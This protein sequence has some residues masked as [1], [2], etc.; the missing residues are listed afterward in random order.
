MAWNTATASNY[1]DVLTKLV[2]AATSKYISA[3]AINS[4]GSSYT[5]GDILTI[6]H[7]GATIDAKIEVL[8]VSSGVITSAVIRSAGAFSNRVATV[9]VNAG[10]TGYAAGDIV[11]L[12][13]AEGVWTQRAKITV[14]T[15]SAGVVTAVAVLEGGAYSTAPSLTGVATEGVGPAAFA[16]NDDLTVDVTMSGLIGSSGISASGGTGSG[17]TFDL[18]LTDVGMT[19][20]RDRHDY[21]Y[22]SVTDEKEVVL[23]GTNTGSDKPYLGFRSFSEP[24]G[25]STRYHVLLTMMTSHNAGLSFDS[26][27]NIL[28][29][30]PHATAQVSIPCLNSSMSMW[31]SATERR[32]SGCVKTVGGSTTAY[33]TFFTGLLNPFGTVTENPWPAIVAASCPSMDY[34]PDDATGGHISGI[35]EAYWISGVTAPIRMFQT[36][37]MTWVSIRNFN[38]STQSFTRVV[39]PVGE[40]TAIVD[41]TDPNMIVDEGPVIFTNGIVDPSAGTATQTLKPAPD[42]GGDKFALIPATVIRTPSGDLANTDIHGEMD[43]VFFVSATK[44][45]GS[46]I[47]SEDTITENGVR[48]RVFA[49][50]PRTNRYSYLAMLEA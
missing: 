30:T 21:S 47:A 15:V 17:A 45:D 2:Q 19:A 26:Q 28:Q 4:G 34:A 50:G 35:T 9:A 24:D 22:N 36:S 48:Y 29:S 5:A 42:S 49:N 13:E 3:V 25:V 32:I 41:T 11:A 7:A 43:G 46:T 27:S 33:Q 14:S 37:T 8:T 44:A 16:G 10:G 40:P 6:T 39:Y 18:T 31:I 1:R 20:L 23:E 38:G 12:D